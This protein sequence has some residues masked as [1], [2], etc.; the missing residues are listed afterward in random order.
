MW[1]TV[2][3]LFGGIDTHS[4]EQQEEE[5]LGY[6]A[7]GM[8]ACGFMAFLALTVL[9]A[10]YGRYAENASFIYGFKMNGKLAWVLQEAPCVVAVIWAVVV[11]SRTIPVP[12]VVLLCL[13]SIHY[14]NRTFIFPMLIRGGKPTPVVVFLLALSFCAVNGTLQARYLTEYAQ[15][16]EGYLQDP[17]FLGGVLLFFAGMGINI[18]SDSV[19]RNL[20]KPGDTGYHIPR[21]G[22]FEYVSGANFFGEIL[23]WTGFAIASGSIVGVVRHTRSFHPLCK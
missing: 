20:R 12:S 18:H 16:P 11:K 5:Y 10:P 1:K 9:K 23:E 13:F 3:T 2:G 17:R 22:A 8:I 14:I 6:V 21:G 4:W 19:L 15:Y 7:Y